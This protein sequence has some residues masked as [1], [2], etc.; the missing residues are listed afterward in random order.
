MISVLLAVLKIIGLIILWLLIIVL[1]LLLFILISPIRY[2]GRADVH[3]KILVQAKVSWLLHILSITFD[4]K[5][6][7]TDLVIKI[8]GVPLKSGK[9][10][11]PSEDTGGDEEE[12]GSA[13]QPSG[14]EKETEGKEPKKKKTEESSQEAPKPEETVRPE[15]KKA[16]ETSPKSDGQT[17]KNEEMPEPE[18]E[19]EDFLRKLSKTAHKIKDT[20][21]RAVHTFDPEGPLMMKLD[22]IT[23]LR[24]KHAIGLALRFVGWLLKH[25]LP[26]KGSGYIRYGFEDPSLTGRVLA[27]VAAA[28]PL[29]KN[30][31]MVQPVFTE[32]VFECDAVLKG[33]IVLGLILVKAAALVLK[34]DVL[35]VIRNY[36]KYF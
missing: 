28:V 24:T 4:W 21:S 5:D 31:I 34:K 12:E 18:E 26:R 36:K 35:F 13:E 8:F 33:K 30:E 6:K 11:V 25:I 19:A 7:K 20:L 14:K 2:R 27:A 22:F 16:E 1:A 32:A 3:G 10:N 17:Q 9:K 15:A 23:N 29:H